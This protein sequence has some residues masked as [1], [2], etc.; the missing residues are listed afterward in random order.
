MAPPGLRSISI[1]SWLMV[2]QVGAIKSTDLIAFAS[3]SLAPSNLDKDSKVPARRPVDDAVGQPMSGRPCG[4]TEGVVGFPTSHHLSP[5]QRNS[6]RNGRQSDGYSHGWLLA[7]TTKR[8][9]KNKILARLPGR[10]FNPRH[11]TNQEAHDGPWFDDRGSNPG[12]QLIM[13]R[14]APLRHPCDD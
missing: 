1:W 4:L 14:G 8:R 2:R 9:G 3:I 5:T 11:T 7:T 10:G 13:P 12:H 6:R